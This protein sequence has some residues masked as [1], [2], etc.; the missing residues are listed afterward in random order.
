MKRLQT[1]RTIIESLNNT[2]EGNFPVY[3]GRN[4]MYVLSSKEDTLTVLEFMTK[5]LKASMEPN[6][7][8]WVAPASAEEL[9]ILEVWLQ[10]KNCQSVRVVVNS[11]M[12]EELNKLAGFDV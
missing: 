6:P 5:T 9:G 1:L 3:A 11:S 4:C 10:K 8:A 12:V 7:P 2:K